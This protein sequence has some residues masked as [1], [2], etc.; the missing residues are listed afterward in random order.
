MGGCKACAAARLAAHRGLTRRDAAPASSR[1]PP[2]WRARAHRVCEARR[3]APL[4]SELRPLAREEGED[5][6]PFRKASSVGTAAKHV[7]LRS[8]CAPPR[9]RRGV[10][11]QARRRRAFGRR[12]TLR[13][14]APRRAAPR[15]G[16]CG[17]APCAG[18][19]HMASLLATLCI[20]SAPFAPA[21]LRT[22]R[23]D[24]AQAQAPARKRAQAGA[25]AT[26]SRGGASGAAQR[27]S[28]RGQSVGRRR[29][30]SCRV[31]VVRARG[32]AACLQRLPAVAYRSAA[33]ARAA[34][35]A[36]TQG[37][38]SAAVRAGGAGG[39]AVRLPCACRAVTAAGRASCAGRAGCA[40]PIRRT[41]VRRRRERGRRRRLALASLP[42]CL[43]L[44]VLL[45]AGLLLRLDQPELRPTPPIGVEL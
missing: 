31:T 43:L 9:G 38:R 44:S 34:A 42:V 45:P 1:S 28:G 16:R 22:S 23:E 39:T 11:A 12:R 5:A 19:A 27:Q 21:A 41:V 30:D 40:G 17:G 25:R 35:A 10:G 2:P 26:K 6:N 29:T 18:A 33:L 3:H 36:D 20:S 24:A 14:A 15:G 32:Q 7:H 4:D 13:C 37:G 8:D